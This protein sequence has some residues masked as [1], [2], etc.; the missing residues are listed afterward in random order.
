MRKTCIAGISAL[1]MLTFGLGAADAATVFSD[2][3]VDPHGEY[4]GVSTLI[5]T[6]AS[7]GGS[8]E[9]S[10]D[11]FGAR[12]IEGDGNGYDDRFTV[13]LDGI[14]VFRGK[15]NM[16]GGGI[17]EVTKNIFNWTWNTVTNPGGNSEGGVTH[18][19]GLADLI[20]GANYFIVSFS[21]PGKL[22]G[23]QHN[24]GTG[25][26]SWALN[27]LNVSPAAVPVP[28]GLPLL[29]AGLVVLLGLRT[30]KKAQK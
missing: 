17:S 19:S 26:E 25:D 16:S 5:V 14:D 6:F 30:R 4:R 22:N 23:P 12:S 7:L 11:L 28:A 24:Q 15:F 9:I 21:S 8:N 27:E 13:A 3:A 20:D 1:T 29:G 18:V 10:F 2:D